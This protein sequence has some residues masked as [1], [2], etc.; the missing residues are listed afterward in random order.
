MDAEFALSA[1]LSARHV[2]RRKWRHS[3]RSKIY[4]SSDL[5]NFISFVESTFLNNLTLEIMMTHSNSALVYAII[6]HP[7]KSKYHMLFFHL[8]AAKMILETRNYSGMFW[9]GTQI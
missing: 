3:H 2:D 5:Y 9:I 4:C 6:F 7:T 8:Y 1:G